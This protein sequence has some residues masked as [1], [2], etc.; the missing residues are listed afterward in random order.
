MRSRP[1]CDKL[2][3]AELSPV[4]IRLM[5]PMT[6]GALALVLRLTDT[7]TKAVTLFIARIRHRDADTHQK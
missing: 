1:T 2:T 6:C 7:M 3:W 4:S 5:T